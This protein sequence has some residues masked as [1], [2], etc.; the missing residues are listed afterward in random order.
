MI[1]IVKRYCMNNTVNFGETR[2]CYQAQNSIIFKQEQIFFPCFWHLMPE[3]TFYDKCYVA[4]EKKT[5]KRKLVLQSQE[6]ENIQECGY[7]RK[8]KMQ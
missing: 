7:L 4:L 3:T 5:P 1:H 8:M 6:N 2:V